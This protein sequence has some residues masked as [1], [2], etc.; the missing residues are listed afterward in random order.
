MKS[1]LLYFFDRDLQKV[2]HELMCYQNESLIWKKAPG[3]ANSAGNLT[4]HIIGNL[5]HYIGSVMGETGY[6]R[7]RE[8]EFSDQDVPREELIQ[9]LDEV[10]HT[11]ADT[12][13]QFPEDWFSRSY[14][15]GALKEPMTYEYY[16]F[17]LVSHLNYHLGQINYHRRLLDS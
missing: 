9:L 2:K 7:D 10:N 3:I 1:S 13:L 16:M 15:G 8:K 4:L 17:H 14:P 5:N 6:V 11:I 12:I